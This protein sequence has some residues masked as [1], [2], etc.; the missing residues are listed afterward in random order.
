[1]RS[2]KPAHGSAG[3]RRPG[4][5]PGAR[6]RAAVLLLGIVA[7]AGSVTAARAAQDP[8]GQPEPMAASMPRDAS[9]TPTVT[10]TSTPT[11]TPTRTPTGPPYVP[12]TPTSAT[13]APAVGPP[14]TTGKRV[15]L[16]DCAWCHGEQAE[17]TAV[18]P[19]LQD[20]GAATVDFWLSTGR[21]PLSS[22]DQEAVS[23]PPSYSPA[24]I[25]SIVDYV[26][27]LGTQ[28]K[29]IPAIH[30][31]DVAEGQSL[32]VTH[33]AACHSS[34]GTGVIVVDGKRAP[35]LYHQTPRQIAEAIRT[36]PGEMPPF[37]EE[38][39]DQTQLDDLV[40]YTRSLGDPQ[41]KGGNGLDQFGPIFEGSVT[42][43]IPVPVLI[44]VLLLLGQRRKQS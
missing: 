44:I 41:V 27:S 21:M 1:M 38:E 2:T 33:C 5:R 8:A 23:G 4:S 34:S 17:G 6:I 32:F 15:F 12:S 11:V 30:P 9:S 18:A 37:S 31:G 19:S 10:T 42:W 24:T 22:P 40:S 43:L 36:G 13:P 7:A 14:D 3:D 25:R 39:V 35:Q 29:P 26:G 28:G 20:K 16:R